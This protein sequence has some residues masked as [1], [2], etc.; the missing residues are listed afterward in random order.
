MIF[1]LVSKISNFELKYEF[2][3]IN[4]NL[5]NTIKMN[6]LNTTIIYK[7]KSNEDHQIKKLVKIYH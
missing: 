3:M 2:K 5:R 4:F 1:Y 7:V 6:E